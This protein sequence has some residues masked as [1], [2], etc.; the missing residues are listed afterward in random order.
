MGNVVYADP[1]FME[2]VLSVSKEVRKKWD[3]RGKVW[4]GRDPR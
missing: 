1:E 4:E 3:R 2:R